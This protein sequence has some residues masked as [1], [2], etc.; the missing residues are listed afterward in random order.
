MQ[1]SQGIIFFLWDQVKNDLKSESGIG[2]LALIDVVCKL[3][4]L[5]VIF[6]GVVS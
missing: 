2:F 5:S 4:L 6:I 3:N 1:N